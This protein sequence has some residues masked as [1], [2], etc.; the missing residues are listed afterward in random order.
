MNG[1]RVSFGPPNQSQFCYQFVDNSAVYELRFGVPSIPL[2]PTATREQ[3]IAATNL[4]GLQA[5]AMPT[6][7]G[8]EYAVT[9]SRAQRNIGPNPAVI[10]AKKVMARKVSADSAGR[11][12]FAEHDYSLNSSS[13]DKNRRSVSK[14]L[15]LKDISDSKAKAMKMESER[16]YLDEEKK[17]LE[18]SRRSLERKKNLDQLKIKRKEEALKKKQKELARK[19][20][21]AKKREEELEKL[22]EDLMK[23]KKMLADKKDQESAKA[24]GG[25]AKRKLRSSS[26]RESE[27]NETKRQ[28]R[29]DKKVMEEL[30]ES[31]LT[32][33]ICS[34]YFIQ[35]VNLNCSHT[36]C[37]QCIEEWKRTNVDEAVCPICRHPIENQNRELV[38]DN[39]IDQFITATKPS[40]I[41]HRK[42]VAEERK[43]KMAKK[44]Q[45]SKTTGASA[46]GEHQ[47]QRG[48][49]AG[50]QPHLTDLLMSLMAEFFR[51]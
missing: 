6:R 50:H 36:F 17:K 32:C 38:L 8:L 24:G 15:K 40:L 21:E 49:D 27:T 28:C 11:Q 30:L 47:G 51:D 20:R 39:L 5:S 3:P 13:A 10:A 2:I 19:E 9:T 37:E 46:R 16:K 33:S 43:K 34:E 22:R 4:V 26:V 41:E 45:H 31:E 48:A 14:R 35:A 23:E 7:S 1:D 25:S 29:E 44:A 18:K 12:A 42:R